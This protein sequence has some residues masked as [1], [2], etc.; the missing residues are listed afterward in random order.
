M[1]Q[2]ADLGAIPNSRRDTY[3]ARVN[4]NVQALAS[5][6]AGI[7]PPSP[8][9]PFLMW[10]DIGTNKLRMRDAANTAWLAVADLG[11]PL[12]WYSADVAVNVRS[13]GATGNGATDD[14]TAVQA[15]LTAAAGKSLYFPPGLYLLSAK[16]LLTGGVTIY[17]A[18]QGVSE[19]RWTAAAASRGIAL[20]S[21]SAAAMHVVR[22][23]CLTT[24]GTAGTALELSYSGQIVSGVTQDRMQPRFIVEAVTVE[25]STTRDS[26]DAITTGWMCGISAVAAVH[27]TIRDC[28]IHG[29]AATAFQPVAGT[30][31]IAF[32]GSPALGSSS[33][34]VPLGLLVDNLNSFFCDTAIDVYNAYQVDITASNVVAAGN[35]VR[36]T[37]E[38]SHLRAKITDTHLNCYSCGVVATGYQEV[39]VTDCE[40]YGIQTS[41]G[42]SAITLSDTV[43]AFIICGNIVNSFSGAA[44][45][46]GFV[47]NGDY[48]VVSGNIFDQQG[49]NIVTCIYLTATSSNIK[50]SNNIFRGA[51]SFTVLNSGT[52]NSVS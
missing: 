14:T 37:S 31:G 35:G 4:E 6:N 48:G 52:A 23:I 40:L 50:G 36:L 45:S 34:G 21:S 16:L 27:G 38:Y 42:W 5:N 25:G 7:S 43:A 2:A 20:S 32:Q 9:Y 41:T 19:L 44:N 26:G 8:A 33:N 28:T 12:K 30:Q 47:L 18:G 22:D 11:P 39:I 13:Y 3:R 10:A 17:G 29:R 49:S 24:A 51:F 1:P 15:A 46:N